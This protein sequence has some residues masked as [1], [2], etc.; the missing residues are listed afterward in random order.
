MGWKPKH[1]DRRDERPPRRGLG[2]A[3]DRM[4]RRI[5][6]RLLFQRTRAILVS[7]A[8]VLAIAV[9]LMLGRMATS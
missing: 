7:L 9:L 6:L 1:Q 3:T 2:W 8:I 4:D 5:K